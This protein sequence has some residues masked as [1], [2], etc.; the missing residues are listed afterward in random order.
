MAVDL[1]V[2]SIAEVSPA[3]LVDWP[4]VCDRNMFSFVSERKPEKK[5]NP[6][7]G[8]AAKGRERTAL[9]RAH[10]C[11]V[12]GGGVDH[13]NTGESGRALGNGGD[14]PGEVCDPDPLQSERDVH[15]RQRA[16]EVHERD[17]VGG[18]DQLGEKLS[19][20]EDSQGTRQAGVDEDDVKPIR[21]VVLE[22][23]ELREGG[24]LRS[25]QRS[26]ANERQKKQRNQQTQRKAEN[27]HL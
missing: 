4:F 2:G 16:A 15:H 13:L 19:E 20:G 11:D 27:E 7:R 14:Q 25:Q 5:S 23:S 18:R 12:L 22:L 3:A 9:L 8:N 6:Q 24:D 10:E 17:R 26:S 1:K 21:Q